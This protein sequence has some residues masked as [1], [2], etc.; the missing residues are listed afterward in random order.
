MVALDGP[1][2]NV[3]ALVD[4]IYAVLPS[5][6]SSEDTTVDIKSSLSSS[7]ETHFAQVLNSFSANSQS[8]A[9]I[10]TIK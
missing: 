4:K 7:A 3:T 10:G 1:L 2:K 9:E 5:V 8:Y 6:P